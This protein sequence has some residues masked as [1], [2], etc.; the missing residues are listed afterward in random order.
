MAVQTELTQRPGAVQAAGVPPILQA[1]TQR[2]RE[3]A[4]TNAIPATHGSE[5]SA[6]AQATMTALLVTPATAET[7]AYSAK[8]TMTALLVTPA[9]T[10][11]A[12]IRGSFHGFQKS[13]L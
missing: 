3:H 11:S 5:T 12:P 7:S 2:H 8:P 9:L 1:T 13:D 6:D 10:E 4:A